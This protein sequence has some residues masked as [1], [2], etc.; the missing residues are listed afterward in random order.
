[1]RPTILLGLAPLLLGMAFGQT[2]PNVVEILK[3]VSET[4]QA[5]TQYELVA[6]ATAR[7]V[8]TGSD[9][10]GHTLFAFKPPNR[11]RMEGTFPGLSPDNTAIEQTVIV[12]DGS[13][14]W[15]YLPKANQYGFFPSSALTD[16]ARGRS[17]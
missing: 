11:Y 9:V 14:A 7:D 6:S 15:L 10:A 13:G 16:D 12:Y 17:A 8:R 3:K 1:M 5:V 4:Y 2:R